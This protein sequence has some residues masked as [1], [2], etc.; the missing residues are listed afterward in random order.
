MV[1]T[2]SD[3]FPSGFFFVKKPPKCNSFTSSAVEIDSV[4]KRDACYINMGKCVH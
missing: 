4:L 1:L 2:E 3:G